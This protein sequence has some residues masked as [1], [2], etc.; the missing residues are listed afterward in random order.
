[1]MKKLKQLKKLIMIYKKNV[2]DIMDA[3]EAR[4]LSNENGRQRIINIALQK[5]EE[6]IREEAQKGGTWIPYGSKP[7]FGG[8]SFWID[9]NLER[10][11]ELRDIL[12]AKGYT[13]KD[14]GYIGGVYQNTER[15]HW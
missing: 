6:Q 15:L 3:S 8:A 9:G 10:V 4:A 12:I 14:T 1:M 13:F 5:I 7:R 2:G 11:P